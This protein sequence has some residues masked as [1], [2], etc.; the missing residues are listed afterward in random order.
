[1]P[2]LFEIEKKTTGNGGLPNIMDE[3]FN[4]WKFFPRFNSHDG[5]K[6]IEIY[7][8]VFE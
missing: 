2:I 3:A 8:R 7:K 1:M 6:N 4:K 5:K